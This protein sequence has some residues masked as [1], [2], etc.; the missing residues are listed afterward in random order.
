MIDWFKLAFEDC[1][2]EPLVKHEQISGH[3]S[4]KPI[5]RLSSYTAKAIGIYNPKEKGE[6]RAL[7]YLSELF[8][9]IGLPVPRILVS[10]EE[11]GAFITEYLGDKTLMELLFEEQEL[12]HKV[13]SERIKNYYKQA[14]VELPR[15]QFLGG[16]Q[17]D[18]RFCYP[19]QAFDAASML[20]DMN[21]YRR[22]YL[23]RLSVPFDSN[24]L[25]RDFEKLA[26]F[27]LQAPASY[28][29]Y[30]DF[31]ARNIV[32]QDGSVGCIDFQ[33]GRRGP[34]QYDIVSLLYQSRAALPQNFRDE[35]FEFYLQ[36]LRRHLDFDE[37][38]FRTF[39]Q[40]FLLIRLLQ[41]LGAYGNLGLGKGKSYF[42]ESIPYA[43][44]TLSRFTGAG[45]VPVDVP[46]LQKTFDII[47]ELQRKKTEQ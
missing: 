6:N 18:F 9:S 4:D 3:G 1:F 39:F 20:W 25:A 19:K 10:N 45:K 17:V 29:M 12:G 26:S 27:L 21:Y 15:F 5:Y 36:E 46:E 13:P 2:G 43:L 7:H 41:V 34:L 32:A 40:G 47:I 11:V 31:Q 22:E 8:I 42:I 16:Q 35:L 24:K 44:N 30:R 23:E 37:D 33:G 28:F 38:K 14:L